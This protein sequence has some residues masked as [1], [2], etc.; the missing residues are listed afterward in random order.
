MNNNNKTFIK[1]L[2]KHIKSYNNKAFQQ[3]YIST[4]R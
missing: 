3:Q 1:N 4:K 2:Y